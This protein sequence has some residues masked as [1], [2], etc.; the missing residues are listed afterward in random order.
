M[1]ASLYQ[2]NPAPDDGSFF[3]K[4]M[5]RYYTSRPRV[6]EMNVYQAWD[7]AITERQQSDYTVGVTM[8]QDENDN[9][10]VLDVY[11]TKLG[12]GEELMRVVVEYA[13]K[14][15]PTLLGLE[16]GQIF[17]ALESTFKKVCT[18]KGYYPSYE[19][20]KPLTD[21]MVRA[22][23]L[24]G[25]M[26]AGKVQFPENAPY[27][28]DV[29]NELLR[30]PAGKHDDVVDS[31]SWCVRL[32]VSKSAPRVR[33]TPEKKSWKDKLGGIMRGQGDTTHMAG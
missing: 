16:D 8:A 29:R 21:K 3:T 17:K 20:L 10:Y 5:F 26:Q 27:M 18:E 31:L 4:P 9:L 33:V 22:Q 25:R 30:F 24:R 23:P 28:Q 11:R 15:K 7:F 32:M 14:W 1:W 13:M 12:D 2:Q 6:H 19:T